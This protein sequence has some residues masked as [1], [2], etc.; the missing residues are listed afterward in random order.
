MLSSLLRQR[1]CVEEAMVKQ[2]E[3]GANV[4]ELMAKHCLAV[5]KARSKA[6]GLVQELVAAES[7]VSQCHC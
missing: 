4:T 1:G 2:A 6:S 7:V 5:A 3:R